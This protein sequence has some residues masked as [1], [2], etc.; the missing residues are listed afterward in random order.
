MDHASLSKLNVA[1]LKEKCKELKITGYSKLTKPLLIEKLLGVASGVRSKDRDAINLTIEPQSDALPA[2]GIAGLSTDAVSNSLPNS[3]EQNQSIVE[4]NQHPAKGNLTPKPTVTKKRAGKNKEDKEPAKKRKKTNKSTVADAN[5]PPPHVSDNSGALRDN[6][7]LSKDAS[8][9]ANT[10]RGDLN[11]SRERSVVPKL[12]PASSAT[13]ANDRAPLASLRPPHAQSKTTEL[14]RP[15][16]VIIQP[17]PKD[18]SHSKPPEISIAS[19]SHPSPRPLIQATHQA[20]SRTVPPRKPQTHKPGTFKP[21]AIIR[22]PRTNYVPPKP[23]E[24][25]HCPEQSLDFPPP[26]LCTSFP[27]ISMPPSTAR[28][29]HAERM[30]VVFS[31]I[32]DDKVLGICV[33]VSRAWRYAGRSL[34]LSCDQV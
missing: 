19:A 8:E 26:G 21:P 15:A 7:I 6:H 13:Q 16:A 29:R 30:S 3:S 27:L 2:P 10:I 28:R 22:P 4:S 32:K 12:P 18:P 20:Q 34:L 25:I 11:I 1:K 17:K 24:P 31:G 33:R 5:D 14:I 23:A 9:H